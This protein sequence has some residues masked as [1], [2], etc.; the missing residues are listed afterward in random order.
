MGKNQS[1]FKD[2]ETGTAEKCR[3]RSLDLS[4]RRTDLKV[5]PYLIHN[6]LLLPGEKG[7]F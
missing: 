6:A 1:G 7:L 2:G 4:G 3:D 5:C